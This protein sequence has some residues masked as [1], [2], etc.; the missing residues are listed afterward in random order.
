M[1]FFVGK[2]V[3]IENTPPDNNDHY[4]QT[5]TFQ[6]TRAWKHDVDSNLTITNRIDVCLT[7][8]E[9][10]EEWLVYVYK[11][12]DG[13]FETYCCCSRTRVLAKADDDLKTF[14]DDPPAKILPPKQ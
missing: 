8:F 13:T 6:V 11:R 2:V 7:G 4:V 10:N 14:V 1:Q 3:A 9:R 12:K 5:V